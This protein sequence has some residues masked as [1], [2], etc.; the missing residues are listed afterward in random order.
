MVLATARKL[1]ADQEPSPPAR[2]EGDP[3]ALLELDLV[4][5]ANKL[6]QATVAERI[7]NG[8]GSVEAPRS[9]QEAQARV[10]RKDWQAAMTRIQDQ[11]ASILSWSGGLE[12]DLATLADELRGRMGLMDQV[13]QTFA[14]LLNV[15]P[16]TAA[17]T[18]ILHTGDPAGAVGIKVKLTGL[19]GLHDLYA[20]IAIPATAGL[21]KADQRQLEQMLAP[22]AQ[23]WLSHKLIAVQQLF[24]AQITAE[25]LDAARSAHA[26]A[27]RLIAEIDHHLTVVDASRI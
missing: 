17:I 9:V 19:L 2:S 14:A 7:D 22:V 12:S 18:Y 6:Y 11:K 26:A 25:V 4:Q 23:T 3:A 15:I 8:S 27:G 5:A 10:R 16:A 24:E 20:L 21:K 13:R 1:R